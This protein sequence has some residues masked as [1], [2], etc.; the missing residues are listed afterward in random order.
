MRQ[1]ER[2][3]SDWDRGRFRALARRLE[4]PTLDQPFE[5]LS[6]GERERLFALSAAALLRLPAGFS[7]GRS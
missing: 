3:A 2:P 6:K 5:T 4:I 7:G 1:A